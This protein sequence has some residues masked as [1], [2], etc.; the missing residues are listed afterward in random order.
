MVS[1][2]Y[3]CLNKRGRNFNIILNRYSV[4]ADLYISSKATPA[5]RAPRLT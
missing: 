3:H 1:P 4:S 2:N 5:T